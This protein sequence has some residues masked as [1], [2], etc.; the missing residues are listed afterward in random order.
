MQT[1]SRHSR[2]KNYGTFNRQREQYVSVSCHVYLFLVFVYKGT[3]VFRKKR[4][5]KIDTESDFLCISMFY[6]NK[7]IPFANKQYAM[8]ISDKNNRFH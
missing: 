5:T 6:D 4:K 1:E 8:Q 3:V 7:Y 2:Y